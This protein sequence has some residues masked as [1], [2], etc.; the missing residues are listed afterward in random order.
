VIRPLA[1]VTVLLLAL[2]AA[3]RST[4]EYPYSYKPVWSALV[5]FLRVDE[6]LKVV[7]KDADSGYVLFELAEGKR[8]FSGAAELVKVEGGT[9]VVM[10]ISDRPAYMEQGLLDRL[11]LK[12]REELGD[13]PPPAPPG[14]DRPGND[15][16]H[17]G[18]DKK[19]GAEVGE[20]APR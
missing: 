12:L 13:Q 20:K 5:R 15:D 9:R 10:R 18:G 1:A 16:E 8:T 6:K 14:E 2:P 17:D 19:D 4:R 11:A 3:A 7:E